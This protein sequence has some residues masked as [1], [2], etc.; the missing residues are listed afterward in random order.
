MAHAAAT[1]GSHL[2]TVTADAVHRGFYTTA[3]APWTDH[4]PPERLLVLQYERGVVDPAGQLERTQRFLGL[5]P[6]AG[7]TELRR[8]VSP[9]QGPK[10]ALD[11]DARRRLV[12]LYAES[13]DALMKQYPDLEVGLWPNFA[14]R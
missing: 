1:P 10:A 4:F 6:D 9:T 11:D 5:E 2:G 14:Q 13:V 3:L 12:E 7:G 8:P